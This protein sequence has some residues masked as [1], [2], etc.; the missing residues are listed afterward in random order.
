MRVI[1]RHGAGRRCLSENGG[2]NEIAYLHMQLDLAG[3]DLALE[4]LSQRLVI[5]RLAGLGVN[6]QLTNL[7]LRYP[8]IRPRLAVKL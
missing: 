7:L 5:K 8:Q 6:H 3:R 4:M 2:S 1:D